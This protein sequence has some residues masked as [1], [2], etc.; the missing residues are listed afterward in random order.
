MAGKAVYAIATM[1]TKGEEIAYV[2]EC[3]RAQGVEVVVC[4][5][6][7]QLPPTVAP[8]VS[9][10]EIA[11]FHPDG[12]EAAL[13]FS[14]RGEAVTAI[15]RALAGF[16]QAEVAA[17]KVGGVIGIGGSGGTAVASYAM[18]ALPIGLPKLLVSTVASGNTKPYV[19]CCDIT[20]MYS[21]VDVAGLNRVSRTVL[22][23][24]AHAIAG[25]ATGS[26]PDAGERPVLGM[27]MFGVTTP[28][29]TAVSKILEEK[30]YE[31]LIFHAT[32]T[33]GQA[34]EKLVE[35]DIIGGVLDITTTEVCDEVVGGVLTAGPDRIDAIIEKQVPYVVSLG[36]LDMVNF[37][38]RDSVPEQFNDRLLHVHNEQVTL[39]RTT[40]EECRQIARWIA[41]KLNRSNSPVLVL[42]P[43]KGV[44]MIDAEGQV[45]FDAEADA[46]LFEEFEKTLDVSPTRQIRRL[47]LHVN[48]PEFSAA[49]VEAYQ[50]VAAM[51]AVVG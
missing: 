26:V 24:A 6:G 5:V 51:K 30:G 42:I 1:D 10:E 8:D 44:S 28:C 32:G 9:R 46:A 3:A 31:C 11:A 23:N 47:P 21:V 41:G 19:E 50:E 38:S 15:S 39:M 18:R 20:M 49:L 36:A 37:G 2:A 14:D 29:V 45:F 22:A 34:M 16:L 17:G 25:M 33:G 43:E 7:T 13:G 35:S 4:D 48:D 12:A 27:T 40:P